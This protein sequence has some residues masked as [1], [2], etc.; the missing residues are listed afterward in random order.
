MNLII[1]S[2]VAIRMFSSEGINFSSDQDSTIS[3]AILAHS[4]WQREAQWR[5]VWPAEMMSGCCSREKILRRGRSGRSPIVAILILNILRLI[6]LSLKV[7]KYLKWILGGRNSF[8]ISQ[9]CLLL[10]IEISAS[11]TRSTHWHGK[12]R[13]LEGSW[14]HNKIGNKCGNTTFVSVKLWYFFQILH[15]PNIS[16]FS[17]VSRCII[18]EI[19]FG[20]LYTSCLLCEILGYSV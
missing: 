7:R 3:S 2:M 1:P 18:E 15:T 11:C 14:F 9:K 12:I 16:S 17:H 5:H 8:W 4:G 6:A 10:R 20:H 13:S 19:N